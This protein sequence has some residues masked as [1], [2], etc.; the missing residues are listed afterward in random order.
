MYHVAI[1]VPFLSVNTSAGRVMLLSSTAIPSTGP[2]TDT[3][4]CTT[5]TVRAG[6]VWTIDERQVIQCLWRHGDFSIRFHR[7]GA[8]FTLSRFSS[9]YQR[10]LIMHVEC[11][12]A[13]FGKHSKLSMMR[14]RKRNFV[15]I[16]V[17]VGLLLTFLASMKAKICLYQ[18]YVS[19]FGCLH[20]K[21]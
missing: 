9:F 15:L 4:S 8:A 6:D 3:T 5:N 20:V 19:V 2:S 17:E 18:K 1:P 16:D 12:R 11:G 7:K 10:K 14:C 21:R 13:V